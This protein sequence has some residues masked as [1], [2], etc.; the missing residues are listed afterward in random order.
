[1]TLVELQQIL[2]SRIDVAMDSSLSEE[3]TAKENEKS[4]VIARMAKQMINNADIILR[5]DKLRAEGKLTNS[6][7]TKIVGD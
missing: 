5:T 3:V 1:M 7:I 2:G 4:E 6:A